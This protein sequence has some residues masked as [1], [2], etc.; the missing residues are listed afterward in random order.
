MKRW[1][2]KIAAMDD[3]ASV[4]LRW[5]RAAVLTAVVVSFGSLAHVSADGRLPGWVGMATLASL[6]LI[7]SSV[8]LAAPAGALRV[9]AL[10]VLGQ[11]GVHVVLTAT[12]GHAGDTHSSAV[13]VPAAMESSGRRTGSLHDF[14][15]SS[16]PIPTAGSGDPFGHLVADL[17]SH[18]PMMLAHLLAAALVGLWLAAGERA[19]WALLA[20]TGGVLVLAVAWMSVVVVRPVVPLRLVLA[21]VWQLPPPRTAVIARS[22]VR[23]GPPVLLAA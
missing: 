4:L 15:L 7:V 23:R 22:V 10:T 11:S 1:S 13:Q 9:V 5:L 17:G 16:Q 21:R 3:Q 14:Y 8:A 2:W 12:A 6:C 20:L 18:G 19:L